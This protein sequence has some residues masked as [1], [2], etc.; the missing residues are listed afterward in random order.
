[1]IFFTRLFIFTLAFL[2][3]KAFAAQTFADLVGRV[4]G[5]IDIAIPVV[6]GLILLMFLWNVVR[7]VYGS[8]DSTEKGRAK[9][10]ILWGML[11]LFV[12]FSVWGIVNI[13]VSTL[14]R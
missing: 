12:L 5:V 4:I 10:L 1:M 9:A 3:Y 14:I 7:Y 11:A 2:P 8:A 13:L 6:A